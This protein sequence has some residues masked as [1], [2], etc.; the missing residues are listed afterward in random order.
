MTITATHDQVRE[1]DNAE[2]VMLAYWRSVLR[3]PL[4]TYQPDETVED[5]A[6]RVLHLMHMAVDYQPLLGLPMDVCNLPSCHTWV[7][8]AQ[9]DE[10]GDLYCSDSCRDD[11]SHAA[12]ERRNAEAARRMADDGRWAS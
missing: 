2:L 9:R 8:E 4:G 6:E 11:A 12:E 1:A 5:R 3:L 10:R 7:D